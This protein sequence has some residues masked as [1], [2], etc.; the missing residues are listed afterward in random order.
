MS[1]LRQNVPA[2][3]VNR[4]LV[5]RS[6]LGPRVAEPAEVRSRLPGFFRK[7]LFFEIH[8]QP[9][10]PRFLRDQTTDAL[11][12][13]LEFGDIY[14]PIFP[15][16]RSAFAETSSRTVVDLCSG[17]GGPWIS[18]RARFEHEAG[19]P[20][21]ILLTDKFPHA[22]S[23]RDAGADGESRIHFHPDSV[24]AT[25]VP[26]NL[27]GF[28]TIFTSFHHFNP[29]QARAVLQDAVANR[30]SIA[31]FE[32]TGRGPLTLLSLLLVPI[33]TLL[34]LP[35]QRPLRWSSFFWT[36]IIP[37]VPFVIFF[38][39]FV[40]CMRS[41]SVAQLRELTKG[42]PENYK[43]IC[44]EDRGGR[45][46]IPITYLIGLRQPQPNEATPQTSP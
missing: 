21:D 10:F 4:S 12:F 38:D 35:F 7:P 43:W 20:L 11:Q 25:H 22:G 37:V 34:L 9:W 39:G 19:L 45:L 42:L 8:E 29:V 15:R 30:Q 31:I 41:Y 26:E 36:Y 5:P 14:K 28:R 23:V 2:L 44:G 24:D 3:T 16:L 13:V 40:S 18:L 1:N 32:A 17:A 46:P 6:V 33:A 27:K